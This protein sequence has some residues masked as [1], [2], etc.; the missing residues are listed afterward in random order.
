MMAGE[1]LKEIDVFLS[2]QTIKSL[3][4]YIRLREHQAWCKGRDQAA[5]K[6][7]QW[8][9]DWNEDF[10]YEDLIRQLESPYDTTGNRRT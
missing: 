9:T 3:R 5:E 7:K 10:G 8:A 6:V 1:L 2:P 4:E